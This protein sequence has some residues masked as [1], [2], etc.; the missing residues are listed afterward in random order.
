[1]NAIIRRCLMKRTNIVIDETLVE[2]AKSLTGIRT[3]REVVDFALRE[4]VKRT[5]LQDLLD[6]RGRV[7]WEGD[8]KK[9]RRKREFS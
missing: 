8:L 6:L 5:R 7:E 2:R 1:M 4:L 9:M 3:A